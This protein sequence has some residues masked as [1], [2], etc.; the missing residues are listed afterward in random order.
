MQ[1]K[2]YTTQSIIISRKRVKPEIQ[3]TALIALYDSNDPIVGQE[4]VDILE[5]ANI[6]K[7]TIKNATINYLLEG[8]DIT[9]T[10]LNKITVKQLDQELIISAE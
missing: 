7:V 1:E 2:E 3:F 8:N 10:G 9:A 5:Y 6:K 4:P